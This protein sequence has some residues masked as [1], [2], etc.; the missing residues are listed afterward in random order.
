MT[1]TFESTDGAGYNLE[2]STTLSSWTTVKSLTGI[3]G[4]TST[5]IT[6]AELDAALSAAARPRAFIRVSRP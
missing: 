1:L 4:S 3:G 2:A 6:K 5:T